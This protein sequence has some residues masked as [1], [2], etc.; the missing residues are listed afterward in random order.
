MKRAASV[1]QQLETVTKTAVALP[2][3]DT[4]VLAVTGADRQSWLNGL[5]TCDLAPLKAGEAAYGL[6]VTQKG[7]ILSDVIVLVDRDRALVALPAATASEV[8]AS[9]ERYLI[10]E[11]AEI[12]PET[13]RFGVVLVHGPR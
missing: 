7:R 1:D 12:A 5:V 11:D 10:M 6:A 3:S 8:R 9:F 13:D 2:A 4:V